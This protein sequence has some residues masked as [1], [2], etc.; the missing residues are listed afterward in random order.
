[1]NR[2]FYDK[3]IFELSREGRKGYCLPSPCGSGNVSELPASLLRSSAPLLPQT[4]EPTVVRHYTNLSTNNF[5]VDTGFY[6]LG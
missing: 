2:K 3:L 4:D 6:P 1:M 5:G